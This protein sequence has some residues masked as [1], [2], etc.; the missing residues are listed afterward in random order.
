[1][2]TMR[3]RDC[4]LY[5]IGNREAIRKVARCDKSLWLGAFFVLT[6]GIAREYDQEYVLS[7]IGLFL[8]PFLVSL[9]I[10]VVLR[11]LCQFYFRS[12]VNPQGL[13]PFR[14]FL[15]LF[16]MTAPCAWIYAF[17]VEECFSSITALK[18]NV[19]L[20]AVVSVWR[21][22]IFSRA[23]RVL[24]GV[25]IVWAVL[26][27]A[28]P[29]VLV[30]SLYSH[31]S[32]V[33]VMSGGSQ[34]AEQ[35]LLVEINAAVCAGAFYLAIPAW[36]VFVWHACLVKTSTSLESIQKIPYGQRLKATCFL[37][38]VGAIGIMIPAQVRLSRL[39]NFQQLA[40]QKHYQAA[41]AYANLFER[42]AFPATRQIYPAL[43]YYGFETAM[44]LF[45]Q[46]Q[47]DER[48]WLRHDIEKWVSRGLE[49]RHHFFED[50]V[51]ALEDCPVTEYHVALL[52]PYR[53]RIA[54]ILTG[55]ESVASIS[56]WVE[57]LDIDLGHDSAV[58]QSQ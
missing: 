35:Q 37:I 14:G 10:C 55:K 48:A 40:D 39:S 22:W 36:I 49:P 34:T 13:G 8:A 15:G 12:T 26:A 23:I 16:W 25:N 30:A 56:N 5:L 1:M 9:I 44:G 18:I 45:S 21:I 43:A 33:G 3:F 51:Q 20:L 2:G 53:E 24:T 52:K 27:F 17:P 31:L 19:I 58:Q 50:L 41:V 7:S 29:V 46:L 28:M 32:I 4:L 38:L 6:A 57:A 54:Q 11:C 42:G 47:G